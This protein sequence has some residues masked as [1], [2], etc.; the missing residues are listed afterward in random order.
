MLGYISLGSGL[1]SF[2]LALTHCISGGLRFHF[3]AGLTDPLQTVLAAAQFI[4]EI[5]AAVGLALTAILLGIEDFGL[6]HQGVDLLR[7]LL[8]G[9]E[10]P[11]MAHGLVLAGIGFDLGA[12]QG[13][14]PQAHHPCFLAQP[15]NLNEQ[16]FEGNQ[17]AAPEIADPADDDR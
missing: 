17:I 13:H 12:I 6:A 7:Q 11:L 16:P 9:P 8:L 15:Q 4:G 5:T 2:F 14:M 1:I 10:H 3:L